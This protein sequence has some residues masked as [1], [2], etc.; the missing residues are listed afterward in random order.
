ML[1]PAPH[2]LNNVTGPS[3]G[4]RQI[5]RLQPRRACSTVVDCRQSRGQRL[6]RPDTALEPQDECRGP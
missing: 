1:R 4:H 2:S 3:A 5:T 6:C